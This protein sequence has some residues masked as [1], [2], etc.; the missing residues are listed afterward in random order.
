MNL[1]IRKDY[2]LLQPDKIENKTK[3]GIILQGEQKR[4]QTGTI[5]QVREGST[6]KV[7]Q[8]VYH[9]EFRG[10]EWTDEEG[11]L[12]VLLK[13]ADILAILED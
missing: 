8:R 3:S 1:T 12:R 11:N 10:N 5:I 2:V 9:S 6:F 4:S 13:E 7:G